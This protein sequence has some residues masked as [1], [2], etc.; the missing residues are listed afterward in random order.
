M[1]SLA[2]W[3]LPLSTFWLT[4]RSNSGVRE[5]FISI[6]LMNEK[7][8]Q[9]SLDDR[10]CHIL[11]LASSSLLWWTALG[12]PLLPARP[13]SGSPRNAATELA[14]AGGASATQCGRSL[15]PPRG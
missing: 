4:N 9:D 8:S 6:Y 7:P 14:R 12:A 11:L 2:V 10:K 13:V 15:L 3:Y 5:T 1:T